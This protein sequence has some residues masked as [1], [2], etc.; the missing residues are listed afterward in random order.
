MECAHPPDLAQGFAAVSRP[1]HYLNHRKP[2]T[3]AGSLLDLLITHYDELHRLA[4]LMS[5]DTPI[6]GEKEN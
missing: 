3:R 1:R 4:D 2:K 5:G 6:D